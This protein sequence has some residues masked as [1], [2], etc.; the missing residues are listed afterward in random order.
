M[1]GV[2]MRGPSS[3]AMSVRDADG[4]IQTESDRLKPLKWYNKIPLIRG[5]ASFCSS[6]YTGIS[7]LT[8]SAK[9]LG[10]EEEELSNGAMAFAVVLGVVFALALFVV[11]PEVAARLLDSYVFKDL[12]SES[13]RVLIKSL[14][15]GV[16]RISIFVI[17]LLIVSKM[18][19]IKRTFMY[20]GAEHRTINCYESGMELTVE[21]VQKCSTRHNRCG[22]TFLF[23]V[24]ITSILIFAVINW[25]LGV[26]FGE[27]LGGGVLES[28]V[29]ISI[30]II[31]LPLVA[32]ISY[33]VLKAVAKLPD[34]WF[35]KILRAPGLALQGLTT[36]IPDDDMAEVAIRSFLVVMKMENDKCI[37][38]M[39]FG[40][41]AMTDVR[42]Y[43]K[44]QLPGIESA[45]IDWILCEVLN[46][47]RGELAL[48]E[49][50]TTEE[51]KSIKKICAKRQS[52]IPLDYIT[53]KS[54][55][56]GCKIYVNEHVLIPR[57]ETEILAEQA[58]K[59]IGE[60]EFE[61]L[62]LCTGSGCIAR[63][64]AENTNAHITASDISDEALKVAAKNNEE[65]NVTIVKSDLFEQFA[66]GTFD[67]IVSNPP[68]IPSSEIDS[69]QV[70][71]KNEPRIALDGGDDGL[72]FYRKIISSSPSYLRKGG[73][74]LLEIG[75]NQ[76]ESVKQLM[77]TFGFNDVKLVL[78]ADGNDRVI[79]GQV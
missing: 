60:R 62:D 29:F 78:D 59:A 37:P 71:V 79:I 58:I 2:M 53:N 55:F 64:I 14:I 33:E 68:Y 1:E 43:I 38:P 22:T 26:V 24:M 44:K 77:Y 74:L 32:G 54:E 76:A 4:L 18:K 57:M 52:G 10:D 40:N 66:F 28:I 49:S 15:A 56:Y 42:A 25:L 21:N 23:I 70:E 3:M 16:L 63:A 61:V 69:L 19:D 46:K 34:N 17:Y 20:H 13:I 6:L 9:V 5:V 67:I 73:K 39:T 75:Y 36:A 72:D 48:T 45:E 12:L 35:S 51:F 30:K 41:F 7:T 11:L 27:S 8:R 31:F 65:K 50:I 47:G